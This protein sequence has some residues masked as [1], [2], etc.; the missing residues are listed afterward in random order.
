MQRNRQYKELVRR[1]LDNKASDEELEVFFDLLRRGK[2]RRYIDA[3]T[4]VTSFSS[5]FPRGGWVALAA[6][7]IGLASVSGWWYWQKTQTKPVAAQIRA[8]QFSNDVG[9]GRNH[10]LLTLASGKV[11][12]LDSNAAVTVTLRGGERLQRRGS[13]E[14]VYKSGNTTSDILY[15]TISAPPG[16]QFPFV[17]EDG[18]R[19]WLNAASS[20][21]FPT[22]FSGRSREVTLTGEAYFEVAPNA[23][24]DFRVNAGGMQV[25]VLGTHFNVNAYA[26]ESAIRTTLLTGSVKIVKDRTDA[27]LQPG[28]QARLANDGTLKTVADPDVVDVAMAWRNGYFS[29]DRDDIRTVMRQIARWYDVTVRYEGPVTPAVFGGDIGRDLSLVQVLQVLEKSQVHFRLTGKVLT[30]LP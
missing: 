3:A 26:D 27:L 18:T 30:V 6:S 7:F 29:F 14:W 16:G 22:A 15:N 25:L 24:M 20:L 8:S 4:S 10:A 17:L 19:I 13:G 23:R 1:Y 12:D 28:E 2:L 9:P 11:I 21:R 5:R